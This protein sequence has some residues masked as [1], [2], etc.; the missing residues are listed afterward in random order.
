M[1]LIKKAKFLQCS[2]V[3]SQRD[4]ILSW[5]PYSICVAFSQP[6]HF[7]KGT[8]LMFKITVREQDI[9][10]YS[11]DSPRDMKWVFWLM[12]CLGVYHLPGA[13]RLVAELKCLWCR[14]FTVMFILSWEKWVCCWW[15]PCALGRDLLIRHQDQSYC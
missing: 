9:A 12:F 3:Y 11:F 5:N 2:H 7:L 1:G 4:F 10:C 8:L 14:L 13:E 15:L 6:L